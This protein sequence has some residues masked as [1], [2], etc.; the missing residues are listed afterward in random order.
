MDSYFRM[1]WDLLGWLSKDVLFERRLLGLFS[2]FNMGVVLCLKSCK[3]GR[4][5]GDKFWCSKVLEWSG[6][7]LKW[8]SSV[9]RGIVVC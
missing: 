1:W 2:I 4:V 7:G 3:F 8:V 9:L 6:N 5:W